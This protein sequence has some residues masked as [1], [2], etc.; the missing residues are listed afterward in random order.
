MAKTINGAPAAVACEVSPE[1]GLLNLT[2]A[3][4]RKLSLQVS[5]LS[6]AIRGAAMLHGLKQK[7]VDAAAISRDPLTG[8]AATAATKYDAV[9]EVFD[10]ITSPD[11]TWNKVRGDGTGSVGTGGLLYRALVRLYDGVQTPEQV[12]AYLDGLNAEQQAALRGNKKVAPV[13]Q[14]IKAE[15]AAR[16]AE[17]GE[18]DDGSDDLLAGLGAL[19][20]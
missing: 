1:Q 20:G 3:D 8:K 10:R 19:P 15:D 9:R 5:A 7:L 12:R 17:Q 18:D 11:G 2:F 4:G 6:E 13:I 14:A 16:R